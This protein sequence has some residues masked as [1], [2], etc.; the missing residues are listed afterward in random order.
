MR[1][2]I[3]ELKKTKQELQLRK[4]F[5]WIHYDDIDVLICRVDRWIK[6]LERGC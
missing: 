1:E 4:N 2:V 3:Q 6:K 5:Q